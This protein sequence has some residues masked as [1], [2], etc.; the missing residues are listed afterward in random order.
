MKIFLW[1]AMMTLMTSC[2]QIHSDDDLRAVPTTNNQ[3]L[4]P[5]RGQTANAPRASF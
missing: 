2:Y 4:M 3:A 5:G 1:I